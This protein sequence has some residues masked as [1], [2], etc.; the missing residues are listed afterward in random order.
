MKLTKH[1]E[2][3]IQKRAVSKEA[4]S[5]HQHFADREVFVGSGCCSSTVTPRG[6]SV[7]VKYGVPV[8]MAEKVRRMAIIYGSDGV[9]VTL[10]PLICGRAK[11]Y[12]RGAE[13]AAKRRCRGRH[14]GFNRGRIYV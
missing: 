14:R 3:M 12:T 7:M 4:I 10:F 1:A 13:K 9:I 6:F 5:L 2:K 8:Q 11:T